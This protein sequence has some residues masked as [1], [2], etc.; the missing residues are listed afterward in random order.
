MLPM[1]SL[2]SLSHDMLIAAAQKPDL[3]QTYGIPALYDKGN[4][5][6]RLPPLHPIPPMNRKKK[7]GQRPDTQYGL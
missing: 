3:A 2:Q 1:H 6:E 7:T 5:L 4:R